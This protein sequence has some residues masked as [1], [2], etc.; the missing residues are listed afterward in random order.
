MRLTKMKIGRIYNT[1]VAVTAMKKPE[2]TP[3][4]YIESALWKSSS[5]ISHHI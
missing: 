1:Q 3:V 4:T 5:L 2:S